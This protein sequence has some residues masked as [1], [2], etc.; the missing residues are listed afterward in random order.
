[1]KPIVNTLLTALILT[2]ASASV[3]AQPPVYDDLAH[4]REMYAT[5]RM[6]RS[7]WWC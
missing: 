1:M 5:G 6:A 4:S 3:C 2:S 7:R